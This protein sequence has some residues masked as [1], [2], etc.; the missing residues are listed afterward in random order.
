MTSPLKIFTLASSIEVRLVHHWRRNYSLMYSSVNTL[1]AKAS[2][3]IIWE[4]L[5]LPFSPLYSLLT[6]QLLIMDRSSHTRNRP[7][8]SH[9]PYYH[10]HHGPGRARG[11][12]P[13]SNRYP[14]S[15]FPP[16]PPIG[17]P[18]PL[19]PPS[20]F[21]PPSHF[22]YVS[23]FYPVLISV[24]VVNVRIKLYGGKTGSTTDLTTLPV[25]KQS[26]APP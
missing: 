1:K 21:P 26:L 15:G 16:P 9:H 11:F 23:W 20:D 7:C 6:K 18:N 10:N 14:Q 3:L 19:M 22:W 5:K 13:P 17:A 25:Q 8:N 24:H 4:R 12:S 2:N